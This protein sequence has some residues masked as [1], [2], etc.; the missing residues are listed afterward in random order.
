MITHS[1]TYGTDEENLLNNHCLFC[2]FIISF[3]VNELINAPASAYFYVIQAV[4]FN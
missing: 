3:T 4:A 2:Q 1:V